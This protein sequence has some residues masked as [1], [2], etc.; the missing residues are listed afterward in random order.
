MGLLDK[1][2]TKLAKKKIKKLLAN[3]KEL[4]DKVETA[5]VKVLKKVDDSDK[6][7]ELETK[8]IIAGIKA[9]QSYFGVD[10]LNDEARQVVAEKVV[11]CLGKI[12]DKVVD[13]LEK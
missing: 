6:V 4:K 11:E 12:N 7:D 8:L 9:A 1:I 5:L 3:P 2:I 13:H 10:V